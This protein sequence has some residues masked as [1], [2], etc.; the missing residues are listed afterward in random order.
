MPRRTNRHVIL[1]HGGKHG[2]SRTLL[3]G[4]DVTPT[5]APHVPAEMIDSRKAQPG[6]YDKLPDGAKKAPPKHVQV[7]AKRLLATGAASVKAEEAVEAPPAPVAVPE[8]K[9]WQPDEAVTDAV[10]EP[11]AAPVAPPP[12]PRS[13]TP[14]ESIEVPQSKRAVRKLNKADAYALA[15]DLACDVPEEPKDITLKALHVMLMDALGL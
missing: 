8:P 11:P 13:D 15:R 7:S 5:V 10:V 12:E 6:I 4:T 2:V 9:D 14:S 3:K 1:S